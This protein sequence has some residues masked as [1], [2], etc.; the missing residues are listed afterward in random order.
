M[1]A[2]RQDERVAKASETSTQPQIDPGVAHAA[3]RIE[4]E[5]EALFFEGADWATLYRRVFG[6][7]GL[8]G[9][10]FPERAQ[11]Q[12]FIRTAAYERIQQMLA[13]LRK[14]ESPSGRRSGPASGETA[15]R[16]VHEPTQMITVRLPASLH[17][18][19]LAE[20]QELNTSMNQLCIS[21]LIQWIDPRLVPATQSDSKKRSRKKDTQAGDDDSHDSNWLESLVVE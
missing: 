12:Q 2:G 19:L 15:T 10:F 9:Q 21:K 3:S 8:V 18:A 13:D 11:R 17:K 14:R 7:G 20:S 4:R 1:N 6:P 5:A 16:V